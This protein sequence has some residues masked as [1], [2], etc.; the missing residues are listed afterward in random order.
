ML[1]KILTCAPIASDYSKTIRNASTSPICR[2]EDIT[3]QEE[4]IPWLLGAA[5]LDHVNNFVL[6]SQPEQFTFLNSFHTSD[7]GTASMGQAMLDNIFS[8]RFARSEASMDSMDCDR[9][10]EA[11]LDN[12]ALVCSVFMWHCTA[13]TFISRL[14]SLSWQKCTSV[15]F[16]CLFG[17]FL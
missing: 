13:R 1:C 17:L 15:F 11:L 7:F 8:D 4:C 3:L 5:E 9:S 2:P 14:S 6:Q 12:T 10:P 16:S